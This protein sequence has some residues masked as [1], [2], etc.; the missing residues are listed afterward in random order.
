[1][2][3]QEVL[4]AKL[5]KY[6]GKSRLFSIPGKT[7]DLWHCPE[8]QNLFNSVQENR[9]KI[10]DCPLC[11]KKIKLW[12]YEGAVIELEELDKKDLIF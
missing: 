2:S 8:C 10:L 4:N 3:E 1:M 7:F 6:I 5:A 9:G 12:T 11:K